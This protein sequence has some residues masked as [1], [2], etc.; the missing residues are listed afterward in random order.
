MGTCSIA[1]GQGWL[2]PMLN[3]QRR[4]R[5]L[6]LLDGAGSMKR[7][8]L[9]LIALASFIS[10]CLAARGAEP[11]PAAT[12]VQAALDEMHR[13]LGPGATGQGWRRFLKS[14]LLAAELARPEGANPQAVAEV[15]AQYESGK[16]GLEMSRF[17]AVRE[18]LAAW[19]SEL[20]RV[21]PQELAQAARDAASKFQPVTPDQVA[22]AKTELAGAVTDLERFL[23]RSGAKNSDS[24]KAFLH[25][26]DLTNVLQA[27][28]PPPEA[29]VALI[30]QFRANQNGIEL[31]QFTRVR[32]ALENLG[33]TAGAAGDLKLPEQ[34]GPTLEDLAKQLETYA[35]DSAAGDAGLAI[36]RA[37]GWLARNRQATELVTSVHRAYWQ[38]N[39]YGYA[40][41]RYVAAGIEDTIDEVQAVRDN[42]LGTSI[43]GTARMRGRTTLE[44]EESPHAARFRVLLSGQAVSNNV[45]YNRGV[46]IYSTGV[47]QVSAVK[48]LQMTA[49][50]MTASPAVANCRTD[51]NVN[52]VGARGPMVERI[53][54]K[55]IGQSQGSAEAIASDHAEIRIANQMNA[56]SAKLMAEQNDRYI[57]KFRNPLIR[58]GGF[59]RDLTFSSHPDRAEVRMLHATASHLAAP[60]PPPPVEG[61]HDLALRAHESAVTNFAET[62]IGGVKLT[63]LRLEK[64]L[65]D[66]LKAEVPPDLRVTLPDGTLD[67]DKEPWAIKFARELPVRAKFSGGKLWLAIRA[68]TFYRGQDNPDAEYNKALEELIEISAD[69]T[70]ERTE[71]GATLKRQDDVVISFPNAKE[72]ERSARRT[73]AAAFLRVK[74]RNLFKEEFVGEGLAFKGRWEKAGKLQLAELK[75][76]AAWIT[77]GWKLPDAAAPPAAVIPPAAAAGGGK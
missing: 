75:S 58:R 53:A 59:P 62:A 3:P 32:V 9:M 37:T 31:P 68:D 43:Q 36:G 35:Q 47:T 40:S 44:L 13:W 27:T 1:K 74:F 6:F 15:L 45:G 30:D 33:A 50:G 54:W 57:N 17:K 5:I 70:I 23:V 20:T 66:D 41:R 21:S 56:R 63:D 12:K 61:T 46:S 25:W 18:A 19:N 48:Q 10:A 26:N 60:V 77:L 11:P 42:I 55:K 51:S 67:L 28:E 14:D 72:G 34:Y 49:L 4:G 29:L 76:D 64:L 7:N 24:W 69:Y 38:P 39:L 16:P 8:G 2:L 71:K 52:G 65:R 73:A 22:Q